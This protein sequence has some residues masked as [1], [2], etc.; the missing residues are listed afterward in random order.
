LSTSDCA[1]GCVGTA[2]SDRAGAREDGNV[3]QQN[4][5]TGRLTPVMLE[6]VITRAKDLAGLR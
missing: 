3:G 2:N 5:F 1:H 4:T 6:E